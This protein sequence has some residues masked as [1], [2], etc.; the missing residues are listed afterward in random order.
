M[1]E[2]NLSLSELVGIVTLLGAFVTVWINTK[3]KISRNETLVKL[4]LSRIESKNE[5]E[6]KQLETTTNL[7]IAGIEARI[8][9]Y[10]KSSSETMIAFIK[11]N[12]EDHREIAHDVKNIRQSISA[13]DIKLAKMQ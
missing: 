7:K 12:K 9:D 6:I 4:E 2:L 8:G 3:V 11:E 10:I 13:M 1:N 5:M